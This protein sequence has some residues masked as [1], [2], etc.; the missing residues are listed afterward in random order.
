MVAIDDQHERLW[1]INVDREMIM[2]ECVHM[3]V[4]SAF[5]LFTGAPKADQFGQVPALVGG[6]VWA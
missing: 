1:L 4:T 3:S 2:P 6:L 5:S